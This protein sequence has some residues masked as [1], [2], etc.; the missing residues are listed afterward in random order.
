MQKSSNNKLSW[1]RQTQTEQLDSQTTI[2]S[3]QSAFCMHC[4]RIHSFLSDV[5]VVCLPTELFL[6]DQM[7]SV[8]NSPSLVKVNGF[9]RS[10]NCSTYPL[11]RGDNSMTQVAGELCGCDDGVCD[12][13]ACL[14]GISDKFTN[15]DSKPKLPVTFSDWLFFTFTCIIAQYLP[16]S[17]VCVSV[18][19]ANC[20]LVEVAQHYAYYAVCGEEFNQGVDTTW[21]SQ[22]WLLSRHSERLH[23]EATFL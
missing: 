17:T 19:A 5:S 3:L 6:L 2:T 1:T 18:F 12:C 4:V 22:R 11:T 21:R 10:C 13:D 20:L 9:S 14:L 23:S 16:V 7:Q 8:G 15:D